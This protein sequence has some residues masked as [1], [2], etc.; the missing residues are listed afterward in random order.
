MPTVAGVL[1]DEAVLSFVT[2]Q[3][4]EW[5]ANY[6][7]SAAELSGSR[8]IILHEDGKTVAAVSFAYDRNDRVADIFIFRNSDK[9]QR[10]EEVRIY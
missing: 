8:G 4:T 3:L 10:L 7:W 2:R 1:R 6:E 5:W 9:I